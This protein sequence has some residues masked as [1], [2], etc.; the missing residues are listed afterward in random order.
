MWTRIIKGNIIKYEHNN[1]VLSFLTR[2]IYHILS[3][4]L[5]GY[6]LEAPREFIRH[7]LVLRLDWTSC[8]FSSTCIFLV[9]LGPPSILP[10][11]PTI[12]VSGVHPPL[13][14]RQLNTSIQ[15]NNMASLHLIYTVTL[16]VP[17]TASYIRGWIQMVLAPN[18]LFSWNNKYY[19]YIEYNEYNITTTFTCFFLAM[20]TTYSVHAGILKPW[21][22]R[23]PWPLAVFS[24]YHVLSLSLTGLNWRSLFLP[25]GS[26]PPFPKMASPFTGS[27]H[28]PLPGSGTLIY[29][30]FKLLFISCFILLLHLWAGWLAPIL[31]VGNSRSQQY[32]YMSMSVSV[33]PCSCSCVNLA[34]HILRDKE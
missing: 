14:T 34:M 15:V 17:D 1:Q 6:L 29:I 27:V 10:F 26:G 7:S 18:D 16:I 9:C 33:R 8:Q 32:G 12:H 31:L 3:T 30:T 20:L 28:T 11:V 21:R 13:P 25:W 2:I 23:L 22:G 5:S 24:F 4:Y 19:K